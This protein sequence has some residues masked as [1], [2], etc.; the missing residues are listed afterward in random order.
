MTRREFSGYEPHTCPSDAPCPVCR[1]IPLGLLHD[2]KAIRSDPDFVIAIMIEDGLIEVE[3][4][5]PGRIAL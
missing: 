1:S 2:G 3:H 4:L 5:G